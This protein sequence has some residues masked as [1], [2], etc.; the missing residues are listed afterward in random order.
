MEFYSWLFLAFIN[1]VSSSSFYY[2]AIPS[3][4]VLKMRL[5]LQRNIF[6]GNVWLFGAFFYIGLLMNWPIPNFLQSLMA[7]SI[8]IM[9][10]LM[11]MQQGGVT[12][13]L[14]DAFT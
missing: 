10:M 6:V 14:I 12:W 3:A 8:E 9:L 2:I 1:Y 11:N 4:T 5:C 7:L 13:S